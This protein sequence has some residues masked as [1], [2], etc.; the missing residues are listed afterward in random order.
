M[1]SVFPTSKDNFTDPTAGSPLTGHASLHEQIADAIEELET[2]V[3]VNGS[4]DATSIDYKLNHLGD[5]Y[6]TETEVNN[7]LAGKLNSSSY[8]AN[9]VLTKI[10]TV[11]GAGSGL[12]ADLLDGQSSSY[13]LSTTG[14]AADSNLLDG[15]DSGSFLRSDVNDIATG[16]VTFYRSVGSDWSDATVIVESVNEQCSLALRGGTDSITYDKNTIQLR[17]GNTGG[18]SPEPLLYF[19]NHDNSDQANIQVKNIYYSGS[20]VPV[21]SRT[22]KNTIQDFDGATAIVDALRPVTFVYNTSPHMGTQ[23]GLIA[24]EVEAVDSRFVVD[25]D[26]LGLNLNSVVG[27]LVAGLQEA[28]TRIES[29]EARVAQLEAGS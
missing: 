9:D 28:N 21:S 11:D 29:L 26:V 7:L 24:E 23:V 27:L 17:P 4:T 18:G 10:K 8:T 3:G 22:V 15:I 19:Q 14:K 2:K 1:G 6:Y 20:L 25:G 16:R 12:D 13:Y 5:T